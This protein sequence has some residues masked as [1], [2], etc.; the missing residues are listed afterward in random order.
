MPYCKLW[1][2]KTFASA[3]HHQDDGWN[4]TA[5]QGVVDVDGVV[6]ELVDGV[7]D[8]DRLGVHLLLRWSLVVVRVL[9]QI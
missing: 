9:E 2:T 1:F 5:T 8:Q 7:V 4:D 6:D 3:N